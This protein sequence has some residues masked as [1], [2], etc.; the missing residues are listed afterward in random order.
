MVDKDRISLLVCYRQ[1]SLMLGWV[2]LKGKSLRIFVGT[3]NGVWSVEGGG[4][5]HKYK[6]DEQV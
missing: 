3:P 2:H 5:T 6:I 4:D 1:P